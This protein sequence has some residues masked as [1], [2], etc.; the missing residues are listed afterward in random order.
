LQL[1]KDA[2]FH[3]VSLPRAGLFC[4]VYSWGRMSPASDL[5]RRTGEALCWREV[6]IAGMA[7]GRGD[8]NGLI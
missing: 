6:R 7:P 4:L 1:I 3:D 8:A 5:F 2:E